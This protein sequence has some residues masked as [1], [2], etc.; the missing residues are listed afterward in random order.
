MARDPRA[1]LEVDPA[2]A[3]EEDPQGRRARRPPTTL[4]GQHL[5]VGLE[6][7]EARLDLRLDAGST[8][9]SVYLF[10]L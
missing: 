3:V 10:I 5:D 2:R 1:E 6:L 7:A 9:R 4:D 8:R